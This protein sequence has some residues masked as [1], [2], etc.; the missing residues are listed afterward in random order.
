MTGEIKMTSTLNPNATTDGSRPAAGNREPSMKK[1]VDSTARPVT[2]AS[3][4]VQPDAPVGPNDG[5]ALTAGKEPGAPPSGST[6]Q[7]KPAGQGS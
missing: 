5:P 4:D 1:I 3:P 6:A 7:V 2:G